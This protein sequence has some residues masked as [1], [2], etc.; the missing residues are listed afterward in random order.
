MIPFRTIAE[1]LYFG[2]YS[3]LR[4]RVR[5]YGSLPRSPATSLADGE[6][7]WGCHFMESKHSDYA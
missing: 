5:K 2:E 1:P 6:G 7:Y 3:L 4:Y